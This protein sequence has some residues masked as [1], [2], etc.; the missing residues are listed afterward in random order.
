MKISTAIIAICFSSVALASDCGEEG[1]KHWT[2]T[3]KLKAGSVR[4]RWTGVYEGRDS[5][6]RITYS[7]SGRTQSIDVW[8]QPFI[9][10]DQNLIGLLSCADDGCKPAV[11]VVDISRNTVLKIELPFK[12][13]Q[14]YL[15]AAWIGSDRAFRVIDEDRP[16]TLLC[17]VSQSLVCK[18]QESNPTP[19]RTPASGR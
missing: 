12:D 1:L 2:T 4:L 8:G 17:E 7:D 5:I 10:K 14:V 19:Q 11:S 18:K 16:V 3:V 15:K 13:Q 6:C 9:S